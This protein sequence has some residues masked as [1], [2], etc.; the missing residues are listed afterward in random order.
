ML[1]YEDYHL[2]FTVTFLCVCVMIVMSLSFDPVVMK[3]FG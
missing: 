2:L 3:R 1:T